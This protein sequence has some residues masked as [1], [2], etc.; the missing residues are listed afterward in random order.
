MQAVFYARLADMHAVKP[1]DYIAVEDYL[2]SEKVALVKHEYVYGQVYAMAGASK[3]HNLI[4]G[5]IFV[6]LQRVA[7]QK[8]CAVYISDMKVRI[9]ENVFYYPDVMVVCESSDYEYYEDNPCLIVEVLSESTTR[10]DKHEKLQAYLAMPSL[11]TYLMVDSKQKHIVGYYRTETGW[12]E[13]NWQEHGEIN[14]DC[15]GVKLSVTDIY[16]GLP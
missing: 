4:A 14:I 3:R 16:Q 9:A 5:N 1:L 11:Q 2:E 15:V 13:H 10:I 8:G 6:I 7:L 12:Q